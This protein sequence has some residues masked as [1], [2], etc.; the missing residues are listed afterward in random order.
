MPK[1]DGLGGE[2]VSKIR[3]LK[4]DEIALKRA[5]KNFNAKIR[6]IENNKPEI[7]KYQP[8]TLSFSELKQWGK[9]TSR[10]NFNKF[11]SILK[12][13]SKRGSEKPIEGTMITEWQRKSSKV[14]IARQ[15]DM[16]DKLNKRYFSNPE[17]ASL[18]EMEQSYL[19]SLEYRETQ[20]PSKQLMKEFRYL[21]RQNEDVIAEQYKQNFL[22]AINTVIHEGNL[23]NDI[24]ETPAISSL[25]RLLGMLVSN[26]DAFQLY[27]GRFND[28]ILNIHYLSDLQE[29]DEIFRDM[30]SVLREN[31]I[32]LSD[33]QYSTLSDVEKIYYNNW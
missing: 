25:G 33:A 21:L 4:R 27:Y 29:A 20:N 14:I 32:T 5:V 10:S 17:T 31:N 2:Y 19:V 15:N 13:Y 7:A 8:P 9:E 30:I 12:D 26:T 22:K 28:M 24:F 16:V 3:W 18:H 11:L 1:K 6:Y 23:Y